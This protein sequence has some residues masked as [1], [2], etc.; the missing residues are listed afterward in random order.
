[1]TGAVLFAASLWLAG[2]ATTLLQFQLIFGLV[3]GGPVAAS[4][5]PMMATVMGWFTTGRGLAVSLVS[6]GMGMAPV[7]MSPLAARLAEAY[8]WR[9]VLTVLSA[10]VAVV[11]LGMATGPVMGGW[12]FDTTGGYGAMYITCFV[13]GLCAFLVGMT[14][15][16]FPRGAEGMSFS[17]TS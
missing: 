16:P 7:T 2:Q 1:M 9:T 13:L 15:R 14:F 8:D 11:S 17:R 3:A 6:A 5:A 4:F 12:I 10:L